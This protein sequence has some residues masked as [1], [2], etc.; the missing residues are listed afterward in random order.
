MNKGYITTFYICIIQKKLVYHKKDVII[1]IYLLLA[2]FECRLLSKTENK[3]I[4]FIDV[5]FLLNDQSFRYDMQ[6]LICDKV[7]INKISK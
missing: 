4:I 3:T 5:Y 1:L 7:L 2:L 6:L